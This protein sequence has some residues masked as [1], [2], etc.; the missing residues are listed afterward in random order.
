MFWLI[1]SLLEYLKRLSEMQMVGFN[2]CGILGRVLESW[3][4]LETYISSV[5]QRNRSVLHLNYES[6]VCTK[7]E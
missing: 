6:E 7:E 4:D 1:I 3:H 5:P 2:M